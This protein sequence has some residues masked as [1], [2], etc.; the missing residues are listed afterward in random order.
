MYIRTL[1]YGV[2]DQTVYAL[3]VFELA[4]TGCYLSQKKK[5]THD[6]YS[7]LSINML[8]LKEDGIIRYVAEVDLK[9]R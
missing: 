3:F 1:L 2:V 9:G 5:A 6:G 4:F 7:I 8:A